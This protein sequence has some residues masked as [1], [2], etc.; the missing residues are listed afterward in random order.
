M[1]CRVAPSN[2]DHQAGADGGQA[3][4]DDAEQDALAPSTAFPAPALRSGEGADAI[5]DVDGGVV[6]EERVVEDRRSGR[7]GR[8][9]RLGDRGRRERQRQQR[10]HDE[11]CQHSNRFYRRWLTIKP[12]TANASD[13][14]GPVL[15]VDFGAQYA[16]LIARRVRELQVFSEIAPNRITADEVAA[17][18][19][20]ALILSGGP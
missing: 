20:S 12:L 15:V 1:T 4:D 11:R 2:A 18:R 14:A 13:P 9:N 3:D 19:P 6:R 10:R 5:A 8:L 17:R 16:Q 7:F